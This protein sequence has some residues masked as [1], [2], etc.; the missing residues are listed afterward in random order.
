[1]TLT[2]RLS[3]AE[4]ALYQP[5]AEHHFMHAIAMPRSVTDICLF[6]QSAPREPFVVAKRLK[7]NGG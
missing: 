5:A 3:V 7:L 2:R 4:K 1:M 6:I